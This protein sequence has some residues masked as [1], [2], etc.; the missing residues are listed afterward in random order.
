M[1]PK[2]KD[3]D[4]TAETDSGR[5]RGRASNEGVNGVKAAATAAATAS[6]PAKTASAIVASKTPS[7]AQVYETLEYG[8]AP[9]DPNVAYKWLDDH[10]RKFG[11]FIDNKWVHPAGRSYLDIKAP[12]TG[13]KLTQ[14]LIG[15]TADVDVACNAAHTAYK[16]WSATPPHV[17]ARHMYS[18]A[19]HIQKHHRLIAVVEALDNGKSVRETRDSDIPLVARWFYHYAGWAQLADTEMANWKPVGVVGAIVPWNFPLMLLSWKVAP[20]LAMGNTVVL[21]PAS[22]TQLSALLFAEICAEAGLPPGVL[23]IVTGGGAFGSALAAHPLVDKVAFTGSTGVGQILRRLTAGTGKM[24]SLELG[25]KSPVIVFDSADIDSTVE[26]VVDAIWFNQ[27]QVCSAGSRLLVQEQIHDVLVEKLKARMRT[28]R[29][30][31]SLDKNIDMGAVVDESQLK[32]LQRYVDIAK[33]EGNEVFQACACMPDIGLYFPP[34]LVLGCD[35]TSTCVMEE[36][37]GP[38]LTVQTFRTAKEAI[39]LANNSIYGLGGSVWTENIGLAM[40]V[41]LSVKAGTMWVN[42]HNLFDAAAGFGGFRESGFGR[43]GGKEGLYAYCRPKWE[44]RARPALAS[45]EPAKDFGSYVPERPVNPSAGESPAVVNI[46]TLNG[47]AVPA[48]DRTP[49]MYIGGVQKRPDAVY[50]RKVQGADGTTIS[51]VGEGNRKDIRDAVEA[52]HAAFGGWG[53]RAA[54][55]RAQ[56]VYYLAE[57]LELRRDE[58][59][60]RIAAMTGCTT[61]KALAEVDCS[62]RRLFHWGA[63]CDK[64]GGTVQ[65]TPFYGAT[66]KVHE[67]VGPMAIVCPDENPLLSF[68]SLIAPALIRGNTV[69]I[70]PSEKHPLSAID[71]YQVFDTSDLPGGVVNIVTGDREHLAKYLAEHQNIE[72][73]WYHGTVA[74]SQ[75]VEHTSALNVKRTWCNYGIPRDWMDDEQG[76]GEQFL[77]EAV[78]CKN[79]W[80]PMGEVFG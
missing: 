6:S 2:N 47:A 10:G 21:K 3:K 31:H 13:E 24:I 57:N 32:T 69:V 76:Q 79:I 75:F 60:G 70:V 40:E 34:T 45:E 54:H 20:A 14:T 7:I 1:P 55:N 15:Q 59:A 77:I 78:E 28:L 58:F 16:S 12:A 56:I 67:P 71:L 35:T 36:I 18:I 46:A 19:R 5:K 66:V 37:F 63:Y 33:A 50:V 11:H 25:G 68:V 23:N 8:P 4:A 73:M 74:G 39:A 42:A 62:I 51:H 27:G 48:I 22:Y 30:G 72:A 53:K 65:E 43:D 44:E 61:D 52:A 41:C 26:G 49:K 17:R 80:I 64:F 29:L 9:E 38:I